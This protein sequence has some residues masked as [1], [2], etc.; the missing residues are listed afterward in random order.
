[1]NRGSIFEGRAVEYYLLMNPQDVVMEYSCGR[2]KN[3]LRADDFGSEFQDAFLEVGS[4]AALLRHMYWIFQFIQSLPEWLA[5][6]LSPSIGLVLQMRQ[7]WPS[8]QFSFDLY[9]H[10]GQ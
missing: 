7:V 6:L 3:L 1:M 2:S 4:L 10:E 5:A 8:Q 9:T